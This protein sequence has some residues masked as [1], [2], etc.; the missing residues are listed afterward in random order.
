VRPATALAAAAVFAVILVCAVNSWRW[1]GSATPGFFL[2]ENRFVPAIA[3]T[4]WTGYAARIPFPARVVAVDGRPVHT[5]D[6]VYAAA[7]AAPIGTS[8]EYTF[9]LLDG[10][11]R[12]VAVPTM[13][14]TL[15]EYGWTLG[16]Y[17]VIGMLLTILGFTV[18]ALRPDAAAARA[19]LAAGVV[20]GLYF[21][22]AADIVGPAWFRPLCLVLQAL[23]PVTL[24][25]LALTFPAERLATHRRHILAALYAA[26]CATGGIA[27]I[28]FLPSF[29]AMW[30]FNQG[31]GLSCG[32]TGLLLIGSLLH[33]FIHPPS[34]AARQRIKIAALG[35]FAAFLLPV[36]GIGVF[37]V[38]G[39]R[40]PLNFLALPLALFPAAIGYAIVKH[41]LF[42]VD[43]ILRNSVGWA[44]LSALIAILYLGGVGTLELLFAHGGS[45]GVQLLFL[46]VI[47]SLF[48]PLRDRVQRTV[49]LLFARDR[50]DY[51]RTVGAAS[52]ELAILLDRDSIVAHILRTIRDA[53]HTDRAAVWLRDGTSFVEHALPGGAS[54]TRP[55]RAMS[56]DDPWLAELRRHLHEVTLADSA[57]GGIVPPGLDAMLFVPMSF[58]HE[59]TGFLGVGEKKSGQFYTTED[60]GLLGTLANQ[61]A[62]A[63][64]NANSYRALRRANDELRAAQDKLIEAERLA[65]IGELSAAVAHGIRNPL[66]GIKAAAQFA[67]LDLPVDHPV[68]ESIADIV[69]ES[70]K[71]EARIKTLLDFSRPF[72]PRFA[73]CRIEEIANSARASLRGQLGARGITVTLHIDPDTPEIHADAAQLEEV[74]LALLTNAGEAMASGGH[75][76]IHASAHDEGVRITVTDDG[77]GIRPEQIDGIF[78]LFFTTKASGTGFGLAVTRKVV[79]RHGGT[80]QVESTP[81]HGAC[82]RIDLPRSPTAATADADI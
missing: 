48:N 62:V 19:L 38:F 59:L 77:P 16:T 27:N 63:L 49:D 18:Y 7:T 37:S 70:D 29:R 54:A 10:A 58:E 79:E 12:R 20:W 69:S 51:R 73:R 43:A 36:A 9:M 41:D 14:L 72:E 74:L 26:A 46:L 13:Q 21:A 6:D 25:H 45:R 23:G 64:Q 39:I 35:G 22:T 4:D 56:A 82:F 2:W 3:D 67:R 52:R 50:Y 71:L 65:A 24:L 33:G 55:A 44:I 47:V 76:V 32:A 15:V 1:V 34:A 68:H 81:G 28:L 31:H 66:A 40:F 8:I 57:D 42:E 11:T 80:I 53:M 75:V 61:G 60:V 30:W 78:K 17:I 5:A